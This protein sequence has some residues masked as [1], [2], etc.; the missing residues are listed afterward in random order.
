VVVNR[1][2]TFTA[3]IGTGTNVSYTW[4]YG[5]SAGAA[6]RVVSHTFGAVGVY[7][8]VVTATNPLTVVTAAKQIRVLPPPLTGAAA[9]NNGPKLVGTPVSLGVVVSGS[10]GV[11]YTWN[12]GDGGTGNG[13]TTTHS[14]TRS[15]IYTATV[16]VANPTNAVRAT[17]QVWVGDVLVDVKDN[18]FSPALITIPAG[19]WVV[20]VLREGTHSVTADDGSFAQPR[21]H[22]WPPFARQFETAGYYRYYCDVHGDEGGVGMAGVVN[23]EGPVRRFLPNLRQDSETGTD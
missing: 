9:A 16:T 20:W 8:V 23:V 13:I 10:T 14:Y 22:D 5:D 17:T 3:Q 7:T 18:E 2:I 12:F 1:P 6:G 11:T 15:G 19:G 21:G 4:S